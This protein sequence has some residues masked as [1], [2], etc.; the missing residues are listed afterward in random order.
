MADRVRPQP[1]RLDPPI[2]DKSLP[3]IVTNAD[4]MFQML[5]EDLAAVDSAVSILETA[6]A[7]VTSGSGS[8]STLQISGLFGRDGEDATFISPWSATPTFERVTAT[9]IAQGGPLAL[10]AVSTDGVLLENMTLAT[11]GIPVQMAPR[12]R[13]R[14]H[15]W[16]T[17]GG[18]SEATND[19]FLES[20]PVSQASPNGLF[21][22]A[23]SFNG[24][25]TTYPLILTHTGGLTLLGGINAAGA[26]QSDSD[27]NAGASSFIYWSARTLMSAP[28]NGQVNMTL[29]N[30]TAGIGFDFI[31]DAILKIR[32][33]AQTGYATVDCL[34][35]KASG[36]AGVSF[37]PAA[38]ASITIVNGIVTAAS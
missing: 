1:Y 14:G 37:G 23:S 19:F 36:V 4:E 32:T 30:Q 5:F 33:R 16:N 11:A 29:Q 25:A 10:A 3:Q 7:T 12:L 9:L 8:S 21:R 26:L 34:G 27:M 22:F 28:S 35:L 38:I 13:F 17:T 18:G 24:G 2:D 31:T 20:V 6:A 15:A